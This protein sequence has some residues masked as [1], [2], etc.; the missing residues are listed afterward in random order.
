[1]WRSYAASLTPFQRRVY[2][3][4]RRIHHGRM[5]SYQWVARAIGQPRAARAVGQALNRNT[6]PDLVPC[7]RVVSA[8]GS[9][10]GYAWGAAAK[11][12][13]LA[14]EGV[15]HAPGTSSPTAKAPC[16][17]ENRYRTC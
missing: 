11:R 10:G 5:R 12:R 14:V 17:I 6:R 8:D 1:M 16:R 13:H 3:A 15:S 4:V 9:L 2:A 7:H